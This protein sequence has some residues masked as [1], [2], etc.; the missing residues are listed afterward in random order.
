ME[1]FLGLK[2]DKDKIRKYANI[3][4][5]LEDEFINVHPIQRGGVLTPEAQKVLVAYGDGYSMCDF[6]F[7]GR[8]DRIQ[9]PPVREFL[10]DLAIFMDMDEVRVTPGSRTAMFIVLKS[11]TSPGDTILLDSLAHYSTY[12]AAEAASLKVEEV[13]HQGHPEFRLNLEEYRTQIQ[14]VKKKTGKKPALLVLTHVDYNYGNVNDLIVVG[15]IAEEFGI[16]YVVNG[17]Y[18]VGIMPVLGKKVKADF[19]L[20]SGHKSMA[21]S[22][23]IGVLATS[24]KWTEKAFEKSKIQGEWSG[25]KFSSKEFLFLGCSP[26]HGAP[27]ATLMASFP[28]VV[29]RVEHW[30]EEV[31]KARFFVEELEKIEG[32]KALGKQPKDHTLIQFESESLHQV[33]Q[34]ITKKGYFLYNELK[35]RGI[36]GLHVGM[37]KHFKVNLFGLTWEQVKHVSTAFQEIA[38]EHKL[39]VS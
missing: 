22:G 33:S 37:T 24:A 31:K 21:A 19:L 15:E 34:Q 17:A 9:R 10:E 32:I 27:L 12:V 5:N 30:D 13:P 38:R 29:E 20:A 16:P 14:E 1:S 18:S 8:I 26:C 2:L 36:V 39:A 11:M 4:R 7:E 35:K 25:R 23:P 6:C 28:S 3:R